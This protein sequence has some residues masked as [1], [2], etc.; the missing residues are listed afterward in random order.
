[1][2]ESAD[3]ISELGQNLSINQGIKT[4]IADKMIYLD[5]IE[6]AFDNRVKTLQKYL[7]KDYKLFDWILDNNIDRYAKL[8][9]GVQGIEDPKEKA[10]IVIT[11]IY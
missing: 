4:S 10:R 6:N 2:L 7:K 11:E 5:T 9:E 3:E 1:M 8:Y